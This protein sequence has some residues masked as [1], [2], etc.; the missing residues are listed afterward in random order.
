MKLDEMKYFV[1]II[2]AKSINQASKSLFVAQPALSRMLT[3][4]EKELGFPLLER[5]KQGITPTKAGMEVYHDCIKILQLY[6]D[7]NR[8]WQDL[9]YHANDTPVT[10]SIVALPMICN[11]VMNQVFCKAAQNYP[12]IQLK[13][14]EHQLHDI[15][16]ATVEHRP[17]IAISHYNEKTKDAV[18][19]FAKEQQMQVIPLFED[20]YLFYANYNHPL[21]GKNLTTDDLH[22]YPLASYSTPE[23][24]IMPQ[25]IDAG[26]TSFQDKFKQVLY[27]SNRYTMLETAAT[28]QAITLSAELMTRDNVYRK[29]EQLKPLHI[30]DFHLPMTYFLLLPLDAT[31]EEK[32]IADL[33]Y[34]NYLTFAAQA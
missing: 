21:V 1:E 10:I 25:F 20:Q 31:V 28:S 18:L 13:L 2:K 34:I 23:V 12:R 16:P 30:K 32:I 6:N 3:A 24:E 5:S 19:L 4:L 14:F 33:L 8:R 29:T 7:S 9:A 11:N 22:A 17:A 15:L 26:L 27:L